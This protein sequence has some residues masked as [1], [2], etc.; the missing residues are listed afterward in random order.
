MYNRTNMQRDL[1]VHF[2]S[3][4]DFM[5]IFTFFSPK[6]LHVKIVFKIFSEI[7]LSFCKKSC[8]MI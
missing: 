1:N 8:D 2:S 7:W 5:R 3:S 4:A 6:A